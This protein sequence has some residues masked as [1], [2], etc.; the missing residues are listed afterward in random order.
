V[1]D[2]RASDRR[3]LA[4]G[5]DLGGT[6]I[7]AAMVTREGEVRGRLSIPTEIGLGPKGVA[8]RIVQAVRSVLDAAGCRVC[9]IAG[10]GLGSP[11]AIDSQR[12]VVM[13]AANMPDWKNVPIAAILGEALGVSVHLENDANAAAFGEYWVGAG[14]GTSSMVILTL[15]T[16]IGGG[17]VVNGSIVTGANNIGGE[18]GHMVIKYDGVRCA[19]GN[20]GCLEAYASANATA[21]RFREAVESGAGSSLADRVARGD[22]VTAHDIYVAA[23]AGDDLA[24]RTLVTT[25]DF[26]G[27]GIADIVHALDPEMVV[28]VGGLAGAAEYLLEGI[29][30]QLSQRVANL[31]DRKFDVRPGELGDD[32]GVVGVAGCLLKRLETSA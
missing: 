9:D 13:S 32:A 16:G 19:C 8:D 20:T 2:S 21:R 15:G 4:V 18:L 27:V 24:R 6:N 5:V 31:K 14:R 26:L 12:G 22:A 1:T 3:R 28:L 23:R 10:V 11:G 17:I 30:R 29:W 7:K 25:G